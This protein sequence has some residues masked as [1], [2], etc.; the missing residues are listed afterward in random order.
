M[1]TTEPSNKPSMKNF[2][3]DVRAIVIL[4][5]TAVVFMPSYLWWRFGVDPFGLWREHRSWAVVFAVVGVLF[6]L[7]GLRMIAATI[8]M[9][10]AI[11]NGTVAPWDPTQRLVVHGIYRHVR[12]P[13]ISGVFAVIL[14]E[15]LLTAS[16]AVFLWLV[17]FVIGKSIYIPLVEERSLRRRFGSDYDEYR[18]AVPRWIPRRTAWQPSWSGQ[19]RSEIS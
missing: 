15:A 8:A 6:V 11:G 3:K 9:L 13:M 1:L 16:P 10:R 17:V 2:W 12:N 19:Q 4:P 5:G 7:A 14:G 18:T